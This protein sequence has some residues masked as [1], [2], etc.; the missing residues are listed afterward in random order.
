MS[1]A[2]VI[3]SCVKFTLIDGQ[4][5]VDRGYAKKCKLRLFYSVF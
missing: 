3:V 1:T 5:V 2:I 4:K